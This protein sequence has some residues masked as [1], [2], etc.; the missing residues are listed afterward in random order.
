MGIL[1][2]VE[3]IYFR[4]L[5]GEISVNLIDKMKLSDSP[6]PSSKPYSTF[7]W[8][9]DIETAQ[10]EKIR[11]HV[12]HLLCPSRELAGWYLLWRQELP[13]AV[14]YSAFHSMSYEPGAPEE[15]DSSA[16]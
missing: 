3:I 2:K 10:G 13:K 6:R 14:R 7:L 12:G 16:R 11:I 15:D 4:R 5:I 8:E 9:K 1:C